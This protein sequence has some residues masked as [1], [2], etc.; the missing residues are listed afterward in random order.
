MT[1]NNKLIP[2]LLALSLA[3]TLLAC[4]TRIISNPDGG[5]TGGSDSQTGGHGGSAQPDAGTGGAAGVGGIGAALGGAGVGGAVCPVRA[6]R[7]ARLERAAWRA[8]LERAERR[9]RSERAERRARLERAERRAR[10]EL[11][12][13]PR[14]ATRPAA[15]RRKPASGQAAFS[16]TASHARWLHSAFRPSAH[17]S[18]STRTAMAMERVPRLASAG[19]RHRLATPLKRAT[20]ATPPRTWPSRNRSTRAPDSRP[21]APAA[22]AASPGIT[23]AMARSKRTF[24]NATDAP[25]IRSATA[26]TSTI[27]MAIAV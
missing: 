8:R 25:T 24:R 4:P 14:P 7:R 16:T 22:S 1:T 21:L 3:V 26:C 2:I 6:G 18:T 27:P 9:A 12:A 23:T 17:P 13:P 5:G 15:P 10:S 19:P 20:V 11:V